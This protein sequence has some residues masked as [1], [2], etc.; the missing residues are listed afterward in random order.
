[1]AT[2]ILVLRRD[3]SCASCSTALT[4]GTR[5]Q[6][7]ATA[8]LVTCLACVATSTGSQDRLDGAAEIADPAGLGEAEQREAPIDAGTPGAS[9]R[10]EFERRHAK[11]EADIE[12]K[13]G[14][15]RIGRVAKFLSDDPQSTAAWAGGAAGEE[16]V[17]QILHEGL[18]DSAVLLHDRSVPKTRGNIDHV[19]IASS[20]VWVI[21]AKRY[22]GKVESATSVG[23]SER[24]PG[25]S[26]PDA[27]ERNS[28]PGS[29]GRSP[30]CEESSTPRRY[31]SIRRSVS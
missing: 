3:G 13:W 4:A 30:P 15:G 27:T 14:T 31:R 18:G 29:N 24:K 5:A 21:D 25:C 9:A 10:K 23:C 28:W 8:K 12:K 16:R 1:M 17:A 20:G 6:W 22:S 26:L 7:D 11:R 19:A 2:K